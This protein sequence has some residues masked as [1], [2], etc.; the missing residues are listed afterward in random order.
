[1]SI[2]YIADTHLYDSYSWEWRVDFDDFDS[3]A[4]TLIEKWNYRVPADDTV[5]LVGDIGTYCRRTLDVLGELR[6]KKVLVLGNHDIQW[7]DN[8]YTC[9]VF[10]GVYKSLM[11]NGLYVVHKPDE[12]PDNWQGYAIHGHHHTYNTLNMQQAFTQYVQ[13]TYRL[14]CAADLINNTPLTLN[15]LIIN[16]ERMILSRRNLQ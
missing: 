16:K 1:M 9:G 2:R 15:E 14:N 5:I 6:G 7:G 8:V 3:Y 10:Q 13:D 12:I 11:Q 4:N